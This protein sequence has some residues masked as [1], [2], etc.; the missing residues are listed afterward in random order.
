MTAGGG[1]IQA[2][3]GSLQ[4]A[5]IM[6]PISALQVAVSAPWSRESSV[7]KTEK[8]TTLTADPEKWDPLD[9]DIIS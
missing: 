7:P 6:R 2:A 3:I 9:A 4:A 5:S 1:A 8:P